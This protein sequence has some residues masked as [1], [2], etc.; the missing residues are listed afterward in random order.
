[1]DRAAFLERFKKGGFL[2][3]VGVEWGLHAKLML[4][5]CSPEK[6]VLVDSWEMYEAEY[7][8][9]MA[10][11]ALDGRQGAKRESVVSHL[12]GDPR[13]EIIKGWSTEVAALYPNAIFDLV[14]IDADHTYKCTKADNEAWWP[15]VKPGG[16]LTGHDY[17]FGENWNCGVK[18]AVDEFVEREGLT[19]FCSS[20]GEW[21]VEKPISSS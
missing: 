6:L 11:Y 12:G 7:T 13:V 19:L 20:G 5:I 8:H 18:Q 2:V 21:D 9:E 14:Y 1:M 16:H 15:K 10:I 17:G 4:D 3:E